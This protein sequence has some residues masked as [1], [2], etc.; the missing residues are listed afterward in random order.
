MGV[1]GVLGF[2]GFGVLGFWGFGVLGFW[3]F[4]VLGFRVWD[5]YVL[6]DHMN[7][8]VGVMRPI[9]PIEAVRNMNPFGV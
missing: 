1:L 7:P 6:A 9:T 5:N 3:G 8:K 4:G 2:W